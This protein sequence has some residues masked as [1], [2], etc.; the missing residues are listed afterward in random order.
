MQLFR[1]A[2]RVV[3]C[4]MKTIHARFLFSLVFSILMMGSSLAQT[5]HFSPPP[6]NPFSPMNIFIIGARFNGTNIT[7]NFEIGVF[8]GDLCVGAATFTKVV[9]LLYPLEVKT[10][11][12]DGTGNGFTDGNPIIFKI[13]DVV[14]QQEYTL[15]DGDIQFYDPET[16]NPTDPVTFAGLETAAASVSV[17]SSAVESATPYVTTEYKLRQNYPNPFNPVTAISYTLPERASARLEIF[18]IK[19]ELIVTLVE[20]T[21]G[22]GEYT[23]H[24]DGRNERGD[25]VATGVYLYRLVSPKFS[26]TAKMMYVK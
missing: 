11:K 16:G 21:Q 19:G 1:P 24:W 26:K 4:V 9:N 3:R 18:D 7:G 5:N 23:I 15:R 6:G 13:W 8:D 12:D 25:K 2:L 22:A 10:T 20:G 17:I 14:G